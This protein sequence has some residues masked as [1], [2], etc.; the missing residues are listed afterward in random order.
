MFSRNLFLLQEI[1]RI[2][3]IIV[4]E[5]FIIKTRDTY[6]YLQKKRCC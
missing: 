3:I 1:G 4:T 5:E 2:L 6:I